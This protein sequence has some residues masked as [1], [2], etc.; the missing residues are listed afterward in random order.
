MSI[1]KA[2][3]RSSP[4]LAG[5]GRRG[6]DQQPLAGAQDIRLG[7]RIGGDDARPVD[8]I[9]A[10]DGDTALTGSD[11]VIAAA[12]DRQ[13]LAREGGVRRGDAVGAR[14]RFGSGAGLVGDV[15][16][17]VAGLDRIDTRRNLARIG[18]DAARLPGLYRAVREGR[19]RP[20]RAAASCGGCS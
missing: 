2:A 8:T 9:G 10:R 17:R 13:A 18:G 14:D 5:R 11:Q 7:Q 20:A 16:Q 6:G 19:G 15:A 1:W 4:E 12:R 3:A